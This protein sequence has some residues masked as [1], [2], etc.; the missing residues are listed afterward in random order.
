MDWTA[1]GRGGLATGLG[2][3]SV[4]HPAQVAA[5]VS[6]ALEGGPVPPGQHRGKQF[7]YGAGVSRLVQCI[8]DVLKQRVRD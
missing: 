4:D 8:P 1:F 5:V 6:A 2:G 7:S 3:G